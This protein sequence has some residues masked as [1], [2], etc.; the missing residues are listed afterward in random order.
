MAADAHSVRG[1][2]RWPM[3]LAV[4]FV[5]VLTWLLPSS[6]RPE[7]RWSLVGAGLLLVA[8]VIADP[9]RIN[10]STQLVRSLSLLLLLALAASAIV[11][12]ALLIHELIAGKDLAQ[13]ATRLLLVGNAVWLTNN[14][15]FGLLYWEA[16]GGGSVARAIARP[17][18]PDLA[19][20]QHLSPEV[21]PPGWRP[22]FI[23]YLYL[24]IT[25][26]LAFSPTDAM[27]LVPWAKITM[28]VQSL[29]SLMILSLVIARAVNVLS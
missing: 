28:A 12:T 19:F 10:R 24:G 20:P 3:A 9:G 18:H 23:D 5:V 8:L 27:P 1:E 29:I 6:V 25:N 17:A 16:D 21:A 14:V 13:S 26:A 11:S 2:P 22:I 4:V 7:P 15:V